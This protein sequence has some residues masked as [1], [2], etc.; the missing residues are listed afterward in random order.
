MVRILADRNFQLYSNAFR[1]KKIKDDIIINHEI[2]IK[3]ENN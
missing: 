3:N 2:K 1:K